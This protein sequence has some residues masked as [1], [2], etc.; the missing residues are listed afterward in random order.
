MVF[1]QP[2]GHSNQA[3]QP[4][5]PDGQRKAFSTFLCIDIF[6]IVCQLI[7]NTACFYVPASAMGVI[8]GRRLLIN[9]SPSSSSV[10]RPYRSEQ[11]HVLNK[12]SNLTERY[13]DHGD[14]QDRP[15]SLPS[16]SDS[17]SSAMGVIALACMSLH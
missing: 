16:L 4:T 13:D 14:F 17:L 15:Q 12:T 2:K 5:N 8:R 10:H 11:E 1:V 9:T 7:I 3:A 6:I